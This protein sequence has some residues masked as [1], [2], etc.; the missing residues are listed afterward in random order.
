[1]AQYI[2]SRIQS[3]FARQE[4][5]GKCDRVSREKS[6]NWEQSWDD[7]KVLELEDKDF[8][9]YNYTLGSKE[10]YA[11]SERGGKKSQLRNWNH[12]NMNY[13]EILEPKKKITVFD[14]EKLVNWLTTRMEIRVKSPWTWI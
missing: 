6:F 11:G 3:K 8:K 10:K 14:F 1:M 2:H 13:M 7:S 12:N 5:T 4:E 9:Y